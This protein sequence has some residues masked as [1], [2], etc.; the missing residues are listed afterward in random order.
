MSPAARVLV[1]DDTPM[2]VRLLVDMLGAAG[3]EAL[4]AADGAQALELVGSGRP[5]LVLLDVMMPGLNGFQVCEKLRADPA[6]ALLPVVLVTALDGRDDRIRGIEAGAD[7]FITK[8]INKHELLARVRSLLR[9]KT[10]HDQ[11]EEQ[12]R[13]LSELNVRLEQRV[14]D[15]IAEVQRMS[16]LKRFFSPAVADLI[17]GGELDPMKS[18]RS[19]ITVVSLDLRG[20]TAFCESADPEEVIGVLR[21]YHGEMGRLIVRNEGTVEHFAGD[22]I[23]IFFNDPL[24]VDNP[25]ERAVHMA[26]E[27]QDSFV[28]RSAEWLKLGHELGLGIGIAQGFATIGLIGFEGRFDYGAVGAVCNMAARLCAEAR[29]GQT[30]AQQR[31]VNRLEGVVEAQSV[32]PLHLKGFPKPVA[33]AL[34]QSVR[35]VTE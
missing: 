7:D 24:P 25:A 29:A 5:D 3:Y 32:G 17:L 26:L 12:R 15:G 23:M 13:Q 31:V 14:R 8:P 22:G 4:A 33:A 27:M 30:V 28:R 19:E 20:F 9:I 18:H 6:T 35:G 16:H 11:V 34:I 1:V 21:E 10:L 2:N